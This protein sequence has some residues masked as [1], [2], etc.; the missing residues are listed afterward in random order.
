LRKAHLFE[1]EE[2]FFFE[3][4]EEAL[5]ESKT[6]TGVEIVQL[7]YGIPKSVLQK[8]HKLPPPVYWS[9][10][11][12]R[13]T[14][15]KPIKVSYSWMLEQSEI[16]AQK[17][18][19]ETLLG[20]DMEWKMWPGTRIQEN[21]SLIQVA[22]ESEVG[23][24]HIALH[25]GTTI[26][27]L[28]AP[29]LRKIIETPSI[30]KIGVNIYKADGKRLEK[31]MGLKPR[32]LFELSHLYNLVKYQ[33]GTRRLVSLGNQV[34]DHLGFPLCKG[35]V[36]TSDWS[37]P[38]N[39][40]QKKYAASD[41]YAGL[42]LFHVMEAKRL[43]LNPTPPRPEFAEL[44]RP[45]RLAE[46]A[47]DVEKKEPESD[48][49]EISL[50][51]TSN[52]RGP[53]ASTTATAE[54]KA[55]S[56]PK[57]AKLSQSIGM[58]EAVL[59]GKHNEDGGCHPDFS[60]HSCG[61]SNLEGTGMAKRPELEIKSS[62][63][64]R[65]RVSRASEVDSLA[66]L[67]PKER[68]LYDALCTR[69][70]EIA[71]RDN[72]K[73]FMIAHN[74]TLL[75]MA[76]RQPTSLAD[77]HQVSGIGPAKAKQFGADWLDV[78]TNHV[79]LHAAAI[80]SLN[81]EVSFTTAFGTTDFGLADSQRSQTPQNE[82]PLTL[83]NETTRQICRASDSESE[84]S[85]PAF[86]IMNGPPKIAEHTQSP[87]Q[88]SPQVDS[89]Y[90]RLFSALSALRLR[91][92][93]QTSNPLQ[94]ISSDDTLKALATLIPTTIPELCRIPGAGKL[95]GISKSEGIDLLAFLRNQMP[96]KLDDKNLITLSI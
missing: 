23:L 33:N 77:L 6:E 79:K 27:K 44:F 15:G 17:F 61:S 72:L 71:R 7:T 84:S 93:R 50:E 53:G 60:S 29:S 52:A 76:R 36:R 94:D 14:K 25:S 67:N 19:N 11:W 37:R 20:F 4:D 42:M 16:L 59:E 80:P 43:K 96:Q 83:P 38:L 88:I 68:A 85:E 70:A 47:A 46:V 39:E 82:Y 28:L 58:I 32:G 74:T 57:R 40:N 5:E 69:R 18:L 62:R 51:G 30:L 92:S 12:Y 21:I 90:R 10:T 54:Q 31:F 78:I 75:N 73:A 48:D 63:L 2:D 3:V 89:N 49:V 41:A 13:N 26:D 64:K 56:S 1:D 22:S 87:Q 81:A 34:L 45:I 55:G 86:E 9:H 65:S 24:F 66:D 8:L 95:L 91:L 35:Q